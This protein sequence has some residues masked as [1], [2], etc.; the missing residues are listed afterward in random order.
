MTT[1][2]TTSETPTIDA[3]CVI[4][5]CDGAWHFDG[6]C[7]APLGEVAFDGPDAGLPVELVGEDD[8]TRHIVAFAFDMDSLNL[9]RDMRDR[10]AAR[11]FAAQLRRLAD[12]IDAA[13]AHLPA[14]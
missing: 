13:S 4:P 10:A 1:P 8:G 7:V 14:A 12:A 6:T 5:G 11:D 9:R 2:V 3:G